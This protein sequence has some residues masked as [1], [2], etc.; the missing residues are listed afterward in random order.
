M[1]KIK[2]Y[3]FKEFVYNT[4]VNTKGYTELTD[5]QKEVIPLA[6]S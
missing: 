2:E 1:D 3:G 6:L 4:L 5:I